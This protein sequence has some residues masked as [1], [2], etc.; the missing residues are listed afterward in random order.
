MDTLAPTSENLCD[1]V[2]TKESKALLSP[3]DDYSLAFKNSKNH[4]Y[5]LSI[6][7][8]RLVPTAQIDLANQQRQVFTKL[9]T[10][11]KPVQKVKKPVSKKKAKASSNNQ[12]G[13]MKI[14]DVQNK[15][16]QMFDNKQMLS[17]L[18]QVHNV[19]DAKKKAT[20]PLLATIRTLDQNTKPQ[21]LNTKKSAHFGFD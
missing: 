16:K 4:G 17:K 8:P 11:N 14:N 18:K 9:G 1:K 13:V 10:S 19:F 2:S 5:R 3:Q 7:S 12:S 15:M 20:S 6:M 21:K